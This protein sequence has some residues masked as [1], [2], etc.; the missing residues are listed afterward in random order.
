MLSYSKV[1]TI[2]IKMSQLKG[3][4]LITGANGGLGSAFVS[5]FVKSAYGSQYRGLYLVRHPSTAHDLKSI[6][7]SAPLSH[8]SG[9]KGG[10]IR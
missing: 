5:N 7:K 8:S 10:R 6:L 3:S 1:P 4:V 2:S 9:D